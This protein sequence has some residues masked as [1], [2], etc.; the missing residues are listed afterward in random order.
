MGGIYLDHAA[1]TPVRPEVR[2]AMAPWLE[3]EA[4]NPSSLHAWGR[5]ARAA[6]EEARERLAAALGA[7]PDEVVFTSGGTEAN[8]LAIVGRAL[9]APGK[10]VLVSAVEHRSVLGA[11]EVAAE[12]GHPT[13]RL[14]VDTAGCVD[15][16]ALETR[17]RAG[18][19]AVVAVQWVNNE[20]GT[21]QPVAQVAALAH[22]YAAVVHTDAIQAIGKVPVDW[23]AAGVD[24]LT[25]SGHK[26]GAPPGIGALVVRR[27]VALRPLLRGGAQEFGRR[28]GTEPLPAAVGLAVA[29]ELAVRER[30]ARTE[31]WRALRQR[32]EEGLRARVPDVWIHAADASRSP[33][34]VSFSVPEADGLV[35]ALDLEGIAVSAGSACASGSPEPSHVLEAIK[36][37]AERR[38]STVRVSFGPD[39]SEADVDRLLETLPRVLDRLR[40]WVLR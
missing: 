12:L 38:G 29:V 17:L 22:A 15:L 30:A 21:V 40:S 39:T 27:G 19:V 5:R 23:A 31:R 2:N 9:A 37:P 32:L 7:A 4:G 35:L 18:P 3:G 8:H 20:L 10:R 1:T 24:L 26:L 6:L 28:A 25:L 13:E 11:A 14:P 33:A 16:A 34:I 36:L